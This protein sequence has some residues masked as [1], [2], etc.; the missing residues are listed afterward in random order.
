M[1]PSLSESGRAATHD[2]ALA[3]KL[4]V[5]LGAVEGEVDVEVDT[6]EGA[7]R[8]VHALEVL[9]EVLAAEIRGEGDDFFYAC[10]KGK[11]RFRPKL[12]RSMIR[13]TRI[14][15]VLRTHVF[16]ASVQHVLVH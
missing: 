7:L 1:S 13:L 4:G 15:G 3:D 10:I 5:E 2:L 16:V 14:F 6:V 9:L 8:R 11:Q 12:R